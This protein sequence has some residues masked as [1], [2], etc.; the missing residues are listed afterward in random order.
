MKKLL[1]L[2]FGALILLSACSGTE[3]DEQGTK[4]QEIKDAGKIVIGT[5]SG[6]PPY[7]FFDTRDGKKELVGYDIDLGNKIAQELG[8]EVE[9]KDMEFDALIPSLQSGQIDIVL[10]GMVATDKRREVVDFSQAYFESQTVAV[11]M[12]DKVENLNSAEKLNGKK[13][14]VQ[15]GTTQADAAEEVAGAQVILLPGVSDTIASITTGQADVLFI[16][17]VSAKNIVSKYPELAYSK[18][19]GINDTLLFDGASAAIPKGQGALKAEIDKIIQSL[20]DSGELDEMF[21]KNVEL[22]DKINK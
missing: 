13:I 18:I 8:V 1:G 22:W 21:N 9:W 10:A 4:L 14:V 2:L 6:Y 19:E 5:N 20:K 15:T 7:E 17:E 16:A 12:K 3:T 11:A